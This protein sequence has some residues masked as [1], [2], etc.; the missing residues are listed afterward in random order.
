MTTT[1]IAPAGGIL[2]AGDIDPTFG[3]GGLIKI[4]DPENPER[5]IQLMG[6]FSDPADAQAKFYAYTGTKGFGGPQHVIRLL[7][8]GAIDLSFGNGG[9]AIIKNSDLDTPPHRQSLMLH[10]V[11]FDDVGTMTF[12]GTMTELHESFIQVP[13]ILRLTPDGLVDE[14]F[15]ERGLKTYKLPEPPGAKPGKAPS[16]GRHLHDDHEELNK[17]SRHGPAVMRCGTLKQLDGKIMF[18]ANLYRGNGHPHVASYVA[19]IYASDG[20]L[21]ESFGDKGLVLI[22]DGVDA[23]QGLIEKVHN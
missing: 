9:Y 17:D 23:S 2:A 6:L 15:G 18:L 4:P 12:L 11:M 7:K 19:R 14:T 22:T 3:N 5:A 10:S 1:P 13:A 8:D 16:S 20:R 21:D